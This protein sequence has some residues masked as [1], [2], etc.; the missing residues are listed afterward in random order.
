MFSNKYIRSL[1]AGFVALSLSSCV[2]NEVRENE[3][4]SP[5]KSYD[6]NNNKV[7][8]DFEKVLQDGNYLKYTKN[9]AQIEYSV[10]CGKS[11]LLNYNLVDVIIIF[12]KK[13]TEEDSLEITALGGEVDFLLHSTS[14]QAK[15]VHLESVIHAGLPKDKVLLYAQKE[16]VELIMGIKDR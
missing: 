7:P 10:K 6:L 13:A 15:R 3:T 16:N 8:D 2:K 1:A 5:T 9:M 11:T 14:E 12:N 4:L